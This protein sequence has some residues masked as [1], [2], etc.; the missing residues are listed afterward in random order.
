[1]TGRWAERGS[2]LQL[3][4]YVNRRADV[5]D[6]AIR[7]KFSDIEGELRWTAP[8]E[9]DG[10]KEPRDQDFLAAIGCEALA[11]ELAKFWPQ[12]GPVWDGLA[13]L[14]RSETRDGA[15]LV[16]AK[17]HPAEI[18]GGGGG[19]KDEASIDLIRQSLKDTQRSLSIPVDADRWFGPLRPGDPRYSSVY[20]SANRYAHLYW[21]REQGI[22]TWLVHVLFHDDRTHRATT[23]EEW[24]EALPKIEEDLGLRGVVVPHADHIFLP[25]LNPDDFI[26]EN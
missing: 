19:A 7:K 17:G 12:G 25:G 16:E 22:D 15:V 21:L 14:E 23:R 13:V 26:R 6:A 9:A 3:Q 10:F 11:G 4:L 2:Q 24:N 5:L 8:L 18:Y 1:M 20:Q